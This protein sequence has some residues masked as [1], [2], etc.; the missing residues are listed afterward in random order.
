MLNEL[1]EYCNDIETG[2]INSCL[3][4]K[5]A[6]QRF[7]NDLKRTDIYFDSVKA[8][9]A[10]TFIQHLKHSSGNYNNQN[11]I[12]EKW[13]LFFVANIFGWINTHT[14]LR[15]FTDVYLEVARKNGK[16][17]LASA[18]ALYCLVMD[19]E[20]QAQIVMAANSKK[21]VKKAMYKATEGFCNKLD[22]TQKYLKVY[23]DEVKFY[24]NEII[25]LS[26]D[27]TKVDGLNISCACI[28][29]AH[30]MKT[31]QMFDICKSSM[32]N[33]KQPL[34]IITTTAGFNKKYPV[35][36]IRKTC[37]EILEGVK[38][39]D[40]QFCLIFTLDSNDNWK[41]KTNW[42]KSNPNLN[43]TVSQ[44]FLQS[45]INKAINNVSL[46]TGVLTKNLNIWCDTIITWIPSN[47]IQRSM[48]P[49]SFNDIPTNATLYVGVDLSSNKDLTAV[50]YF[51]INNNKHH[52]KTQYYLP[53]ESLNSAADKEYYKTQAKKGNI[54]LIDGEVVNYDIIVEDIININ[55]QHY[56]TKILYD[57]WNASQFVLRCKENFL[58][59]EPFSQTIANFNRPTLN[60]ERIIYNNEVVIDNNEITIWMFNNVHL[61]QDSNGNVKPSKENKQNKIDGVISMLMCEGYY[62]ITPQTNFTIL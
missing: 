11:F 40:S 61:R 32:G 62:L 24:D 28:D 25:L 23:R 20:A 35:Y 52:F 27:T 42:I 37:K 60:F 43:I 53:K 14:N 50:T 38:N 1:I 54:K 56:I 41:D 46:E 10:V 16:S 12:L 17:A 26:S 47:I 45:E 33:R 18:I 30:E 49:L 21:Q 19:G 59:L 31:T 29:E 22:A 39:D 57:T 8:K 4:I 9:K 15:R 58:P 51:W 44:S 2:K 36:N 7:Q 6:V 48:Q 55:K 13:Q 5:Q 3:E 34:F